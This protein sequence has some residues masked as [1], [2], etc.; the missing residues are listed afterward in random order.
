MIVTS[1]KKIGADIISK[2]GGAITQND[3]A[4][5]LGVYFDNSLIFH[6]HVKNV[7]C[8]ASRAV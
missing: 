5:F 2:K 8:K 7:C 1:R 3:L 6:E 4:I